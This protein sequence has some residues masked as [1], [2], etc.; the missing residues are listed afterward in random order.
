MEKIKSLL[1]GASS[2]KRILVLILGW[3]FG[4][5]LEGVAG[6][7][8]PV[9]IPAGIMAAIGFSPLFSVTVCLIANTTPTPFATVGIPVITLSGVTG[10]DAGLIGYNV[11]LQLLLP[12][13]ILPFVLVAITGKSPKA[14]KGVF[15]PTLFAGL[16]FGLPLVFCARF[17]GP[18]LPTLVGSICSLTVTVISGKR[19]CK[20][21]PENR[22][23]RLQSAMRVPVPPRETIRIFLPFLLILAIVL[24]A[25]CVPALKEAL[26]AAK[27]SLA[28]QPVPGAAP[29]SFAWANTPGVIILAATL[30]SSRILG[31]PI[32]SLLRI[33]GETV[34]GLRKSAATV[35]TVVAMAKVMNYGGM[36]DIIAVVLIALFGTLYPLVA[37]AVGTLGTFITGSDTTCCVLFGNLQAGAA[38]AI[39]ANPAWVAASNLSGAAIGKM[40]SPQSIAVGATLD[41]LGGKEG[42]ILRT[43]LKYCVFFVALVCGTAFV[44]YLFL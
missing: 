3:G 20:D 29:L 33:A 6:F 1:A 39:G 26:S 42:E 2:D 21:T 30:V 19:L 35:L 36:I 38:N 23:Y 18:E 11:A 13:V 15:L 16:S 7:G 9:L 5:F 22:K 28:L 40:I 24:C 14:I 27:S 25:G 4:G 32:R 10:I 41:G 8:T 12:C 34:F 37:P 31:F 17:A 44:G 43:T